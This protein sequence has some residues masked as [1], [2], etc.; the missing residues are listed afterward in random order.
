MSKP[1]ATSV[2][3]QECSLAL[4]NRNNIVAK[5]TMYKRKG[6][7]EKLH[8]VHLGDAYVCVSIHSVILDKYRQLPLSFPINEDITT[9]ESS[10]GTMVAWPKELVIV[11]DEYPMISDENEAVD[12]G[13][14]GYN[15]SN[16]ETFT[17]MIDD[18]MCDPEYTEKVFPMDKCVFEL[19]VNFYIALDEV[20]DVCQMDRLNC[21][22]IIAY[23]RYLYENYGSSRERFGF[24]YPGTVNQF[25]DI[26]ISKTNQTHQTIAQRLKNCQKNQVIFLPYCIRR[27]WVSIVIDPSFE[28]VYYLDSTNAGPNDS[29]VSIVNLGITS[30]SMADKGKKQILFGLRSSIAAIWEIKE[31]IHIIVFVVAG[32]VVILEFNKN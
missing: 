6:A 12:L 30:H 26:K 3:A 13:D 29:T 9:I 8:T 20:S 15:E 22:V 7:D 14:D 27:H 24:C 16:V 11:G 28:E 18:M 10:I 17:Q 4:D 2:E 32:H 25:E 21:R 5:A 19:E 31:K 1:K 23:M